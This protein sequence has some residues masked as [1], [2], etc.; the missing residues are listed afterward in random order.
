[1]EVIVV[2]PSAA[3]IDAGALGVD[4]FAAFRV[5][6]AGP[7]TRR[8]AAAALGMLAARAPIV[9]LIED[10]SFPD[11]AWARALIRAH[12]G[13]FAGVGP[14]VENANPASVMSWVNFILTYSAF[15]G[16]VQA[17]QRDMLPWHNSAYKREAL[18][19]FA[20]RLDRL[21]DWEGTLQE[22]LRAGGRTLYL[23]PA[24]RT[25][26]MNVS[27]IAS[28]MKLNLQ[29][30]RIL[31]ARRAERERWPRWHRLLRAGA[32]PVYP[33]IQLRQLMPRISRIGIPPPLM[34]RVWP[35]L[36]MALIVA[37]IGEALGLAAGVGDAIAKMEDFELNRFKHLS[38]QEAREARAAESS[39]GRQQGPPCVPR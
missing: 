25:H 23:E 26:H 32:F 4:E 14:A 6:V 3:A 19:P 39:D 11:P 8:G 5:V 18:V 24:A 16:P 33:V 1:M 21:L 17:G 9:G 28:T 22:A 10:H 35:S 36:A 20:D 34:P 12:E 7:I 15:A 29:R 31:G 37:A 2:A 13:S 38:Q 27:G 30:G